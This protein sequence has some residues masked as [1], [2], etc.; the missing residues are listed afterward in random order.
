[1]AERKPKDERKEERNPQ[2]ER[3]D[4]FVKKIAVVPKEEV[5]EKRAEYEREREEKRAG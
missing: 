3:F 5:N 2:W 4:A 1:M